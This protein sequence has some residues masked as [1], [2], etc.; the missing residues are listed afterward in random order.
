[1]PLT[2]KDQNKAHMLYHSLQENQLHP[3][4]AQQNGIDGAMRVPL[5]GKYVLSI[6]SRHD[7][8]Y[9]AFADFC[10]LMD[11]EIIYGGMGYMDG[12]K[13]FLSEQQ[14]LNEIRRLQQLIQSSQ[15]SSEIAVLMAS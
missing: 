7:I 9:D 2:F 3:E 12:V 13:K 14:V 8:V 10:L 1:M 4:W 6:H 15:N 5:G 11:D